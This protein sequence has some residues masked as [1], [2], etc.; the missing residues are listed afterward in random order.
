[1]LRIITIKRKKSCAFPPWGRIIKPSST[2][3]KFKD[4]EINN[5]FTPFRLR[6]KGAR[7]SEVEARILSNIQAKQNGL[8]MNGD[9][10]SR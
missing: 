6:P 5:N 9:I 7:Q 3:T 10:L 2:N 8:A 4:V 1:M